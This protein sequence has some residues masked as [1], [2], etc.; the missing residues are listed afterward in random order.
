LSRFRRMCF[1]GALLFLCVRIFGKVIL[2][3]K[4]FLEGVCSNQ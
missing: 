2:D 3:R 4:V 1:K